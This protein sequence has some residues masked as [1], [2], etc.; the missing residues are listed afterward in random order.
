MQIDANKGYVALLGWSLD[1]IEAAADF[2]RRYVVVSH[3]WA[4]EY[5]KQQEELDF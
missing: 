4:E 5:C 2:G 3:G 1:A